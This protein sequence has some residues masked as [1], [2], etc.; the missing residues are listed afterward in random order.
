M[1]ATFTP[2]NKIAFDYNGSRRVG[3][4]VK[5]ARDYFALDT[6]IADPKKN[7]NTVKHFTKDKTSNIR[8]IG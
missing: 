3:T 5:T 8:V 4:I 7:G 1:I 6:G 2:N